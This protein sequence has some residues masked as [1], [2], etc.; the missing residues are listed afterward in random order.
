MTEPHWGKNRGRNVT[1]ATLEYI[2]NDL[3][4]SKDER[5][6]DIGQILEDFYPE[7]FFE[8]DQLVIL[9]KEDW[10]Y[11]DTIY[12]EG[13]AEF[14]W[15]EEPTP[16][17]GYQGWEVDAGTDDEG[18]SVGRKIAP[19]DIERMLRAIELQ[20][21]GYAKFDIAA[22]LGCNRLHDKLEVQRRKD[23]IEMTEFEWEVID[24]ILENAGI[25]PIDTEEEVNS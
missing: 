16:P 6:L 13:A 21:Y 2:K 8:G 10:E 11:L 25:A 12:P 3:K 20:S 9:T 1:Q 17:S 7:G 4:Q 24:W 19:K 18:E 22:Q 5:S 23:K 14:G 15:T